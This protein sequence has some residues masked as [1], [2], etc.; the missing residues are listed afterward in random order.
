MKSSKAKIAPITHIQPIASLKKPRF[1]F[2]S[3]PVLFS[4]IR[5]LNRIAVR[6]LAVA[7]A[8]FLALVDFAE[9]G[10]ARHQRLAQRGDVLGVE[11]DLRALAA[12]R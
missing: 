7:Q 10:A 1:I 12:R 3:I 6:V 9:T 5:Q 4:P 11:H 2:G 8:E